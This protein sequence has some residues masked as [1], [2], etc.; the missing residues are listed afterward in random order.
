MNSPRGLTWPQMDPENTEAYARVARVAPWLNPH[1]CTESAGNLPAWY[2][3]G[4]P[5]P[6][7]M[8]YDDGDPDLAYAV[9]NAMFEQYENYKDAAP[10]A[11]GYALERQKL[12]WILPY[13]EG[14][15][16]YYEEKGLWT[17]AH[18]ANQDKL[19]KR[20]DVLT[21]VWKAYKAD[22]KEDFYDGWME[23][24]YAGLKEAGFDPL[25]R[26]F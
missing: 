9:T 12:E 6:I 8:M 3:T 13:H 18:Q 10:A 2:S 16:R 15:I 20:Q 23:A 26:T 24:R 11:N 21:Q 25:W 1:Q 17:E 7:L 5:Y 19:V 4:A 22:P 14:A